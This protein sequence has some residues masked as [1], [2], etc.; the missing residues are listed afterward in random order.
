M[1]ALL[2]SG[3]GYYPAAKVENVLKG[4]KIID[5]INDLPRFMSLLEECHEDVE[6]I[7]DLQLKILD[8]DVSEES[9]NLIKDHL[10]DYDSLKH[11]NIYLETETF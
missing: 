8:L 1:K 5:V 6:D 4:N 7:E 11:T 9:F 10:C 3:Y 2:V